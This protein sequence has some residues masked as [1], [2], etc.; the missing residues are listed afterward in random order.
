MSFSVSEKVGNLFLI[1]IHF[2]N[3]IMCLYTIGPPGVGRNELKRRLIAS[4]PEHFASAI[5]RK[6]HNILIP[7]VLILSMH[8]A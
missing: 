4:D 5:P 8:Q 6:F 2:S 1:S 3:V 7:C